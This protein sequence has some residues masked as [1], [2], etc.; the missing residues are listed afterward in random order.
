MRFFPISWKNSN[1]DIS[2][3]FLDKFFENWSAYSSYVYLLLKNTFAINIIGNSAK[4]FESLLRVLW[5]KLTIE[6]PYML[7]DILFSADSD[8]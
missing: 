6:P 2:N 4:N 7:P 5:G 8:F 3:L 1:F